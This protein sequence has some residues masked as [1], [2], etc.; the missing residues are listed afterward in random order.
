MVDEVPRGG[1]DG[2]AAVQTPGEAAEHALAELVRGAPAGIRVECRD[3]DTLTLTQHN[4]RQEAEAQADDVALVVTLGAV[5]AADDAHVVAA[6]DEVLV[7]ELDVRVDS[8]G[9]RIDVRRD[10]TDLHG[11]G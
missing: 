2:D 7:Q 6:R 3:V 1:T 11:R 10:E 4:Q 8:A 5:D 9:E